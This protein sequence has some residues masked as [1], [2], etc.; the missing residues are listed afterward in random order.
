MPT[1]RK[2]IDWDTIQDKKQKKIA[3]SKRREQELKKKKQLTI[4][5]N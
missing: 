5:R 3:E 4:P 1:I 2:D